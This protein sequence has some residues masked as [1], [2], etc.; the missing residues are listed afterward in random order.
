M[1]K[2]KLAVLLLQGALAVSVASVAYA[3]SFVKGHY[4]P[5]DKKLSKEWIASL[6][7]KGKPTIY[8]GKA[9][10]A[11]GMP[12]GGI[13]AGQ[14]YVRGDGSLAK[15]WIS[16]NAH[17]TGYGH[18]KTN[19]MKT[20]FGPTFSSYAPRRPLAPFAQGF[21]VIAENADGK[22]RAV[23]NKDGFDQ[24]EF[25]GRYPLAMINYRG[26]KAVPVS[27]SAE[28]FSP[29]CPLNAKDSALP[30]TILRYR[31]TNN[32]KKPT[33]VQLAGWLENFVAKE[34]YD[35]P[36]AMR[37]NTVSADGKIRSVFMDVELTGKKVD[38]KVVMF[39]NFEKGFANWTVTGRAF[40]KKPASGSLGRQS[41]ITGF[42]GKGFA[43]SFHGDDVSTG[44]MVSKEFTIS[45]PYI[46]YIVGGGNHVGKTEFQ[47][48]VDG[49]VVRSMSGTKNSS[50][51]RKSWNVKKF[52]GKK[53]R[54]V[55]LD[56]ARG[57]WG[58]IMVDDIAFADLPFV[59][60]KFSKDHS[61]YGNISLSAIDDSAEAY[62]NFDLKK[63]R[64]GQK[65]SAK[66][67]AKVKFDNTKIVGGV[68][69]AATLAP[70]QSKTFTFVVSWYFP[71]RQDPRKNNVWNWS[72]RLSAKRCNRVGQMYENWFDSSKAVAKHIVDNYD[73]LDSQTREFV[74]AYYED[75]TMPYWLTERLAM[76][77]S[78]LATETVQWW[79]NGRFW[80]W[81]GVGSCYGCCTH[82]WNYEHTVARLFPELDRSTRV[83]QDFNPADGFR[84]DGGVRTRGKYDGSVALDGHA[85]A[86]LK[87]LRIHQMSADDKFLKANW[88]RIK[89][90]MEFL[91]RHDR[92]KNGLI[93]GK[94]FNTYDISFFG[95]NTYVGS[96]YLAALKA[97][98]IMGDKMGDHKTADRYRKLAKLGSENSVKKLW[99][100]EYF[101]QD[102]NELKRK[103]QYG[104]GCLSDQIFGQTWSTQLG[105][106][107]IYPR[108]NIRSVLKSIWKYNWAPDVAPQ[109]KHFKPERF[110]ATPGQAGLFICTWPRTKHPDTFG[111]R[112]RNEVWTGIEY[113]VA[114][115]MIAEGMLTEALT[116]I[117]AIQNRYDGT[118]HNPWNEIECGDHYARAMASWGCLLA[119]GGFE[120]DGPAGM[121]G[122]NPVM[123]P[124]NFKSFYTSA[125]SWGTIQQTRKADQ[126]VNTFDVRYGKLI[127]KTIRLTVPEGKTVK[128]VAVTVAD[129][130]VTAQ[131][132]LNKNQVTVKIPTGLTASKGA[133]VKIVLNW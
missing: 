74:K 59:Q 27:V 87:A 20:A 115:N 44:K 6:S 114:T 127:A 121:I 113:Q 55:I 13:C 4:V 33:K 28:V 126:Q 92:R 8:K 76:P 46:E 63:F 79:K 45:K 1:K 73:R 41:R 18:V 51:V 60:E 35:N 64:R 17:N 3:K 56:R 69:S 68:K 50:L 109:N 66:K 112:Y 52:I 54:F 82:V 30:G 15:Y 10:W 72:K 67:V 57:P 65:L 123:T 71:N 129:K 90:A 84:K 116:M 75:N 93:E 125:T 106:G 95:A 110:Y 19:R 130:P 47:L 16:N 97:A 34:L 102:V 128:N 89:R 22:Y 26:K 58:H 94:Q 5:A 42:N 124:Q 99:N 53:A 12:V 111:V 70:G 85:G 103:H 25:Q 83:M 81:E 120:Y 107:Y 14:L 23:L 118:Q 86:I 78:T 108:K 29:F 61:Y 80:A 31:V 21:E 91:I 131:L 11:I 7:D 38:R 96:L 9:L 39:D 105:L 49:K 117:K 32:S 104:K 98:A 132:K 122:M 48:V 2:S 119:L 133:K 62:A 101:I 36:A 24:I 88:H 37:R 40:G 43:N 100:G 77:I